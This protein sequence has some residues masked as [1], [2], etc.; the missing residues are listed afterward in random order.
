MA[1]V[2]SGKSF[3]YVFVMGS[4][5]VV[6]GTSFL[7]WMNDG[8]RLHSNGVRGLVEKRME[9]RILGSHVWENIGSG[10]EWQRRW[11]VVGGKVLA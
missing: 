4:L 11:W 6:D 3:V 10:S 1:R 5:A 7:P 2:L 8:T 9:I